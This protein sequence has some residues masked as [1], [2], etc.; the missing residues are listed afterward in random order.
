[1]RKAVLI[2]VVTML[3]G[4]L[5]ETDV[6]ACR[7]SRLARVYSGAVSKPVKGPPGQ[8]TI[9]YY[10]CG[11]AFGS[12]SP[13][14]TGI[15]EC[16]LLDDDD[17]NPKKYKGHL[18]CPITGYWLASFPH[19]LPQGWYTLV[20]IGSSGFQPPSPPPFYCRGKERGVAINKADC[21]GASGTY[22][23]PA[24]KVTRCYLEDTSSHQQYNAVTLMSGGGTWSAIFPAV[25]K[26]NYVARVEADDLSTDAKGPFPCP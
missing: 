4:A 2:A 8:V 14:E 21:K 3:V 22:S 25:P 26:A 13:P 9:G 16:Y 1:M 15:K 24:T 12:Y 11:S 23:A 10:S 18:T 19:P 7:R 20:V 6:S 5:L 17:T